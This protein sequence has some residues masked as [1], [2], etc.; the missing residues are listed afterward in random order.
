MLSAENM[1]EIRSRLVSGFNPKTIYLFG[2]RAR[3]QAGP[4]SDVDLL[5]VDDDKQFLKDRGVD[6]NMALYPRDFHLDLLYYSEEQ[7]KRKLEEKRFF[8]MDIIRD[9]Q[10]LYERQ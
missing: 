7:F 4:E 5:V 8:F 1:D 2:S 9:G 3:G 6:M 10:V